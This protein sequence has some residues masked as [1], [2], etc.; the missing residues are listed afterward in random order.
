VASIRDGKV[1]S[2]YSCTTDEERA[3][4]HLNRMRKQ[5][6]T[7]IGI[8]ERT[9]KPRGV[10]APPKLRQ[11]AQGS[12]FAKDKPDSKQT[13][14]LLPG[15]FG[16]LGYKTAADFENNP[17]DWDEYV[18]RYWGKMKKCGL[19]TVVGHKLPWIQN[20]ETD[21][22]EICLS[23]TQ[24]RKLFG[25]VAK[26]PRLL[27]CGAFACAW[28]KGKQR[29]VK[30]TA[31]P[32]DVIATEAAQ[33][34]KHVVKLYNAYELVN[35]ATDSRGDRDD[36]YAMTV[37]RVYPMRGEMY[38]WAESVEAHSRE[39]QVVFEDHYG[40]GSDIE[41]A[42]SSF[43]ISKTQKDDWVDGICH[44]EAESERKCRTFAR[45][46]VNTVEELGK[47]GIK[48]QDLHTG[49]V[50]VTKGGIWKIL[51]LG[52]SGTGRGADVTPLY[53]LG[54]GRMK[55]GA[56]YR[57]KGTPFTIEMI[58]TGYRIHRGGKKVAERSTKKAAL[59]WIKRNR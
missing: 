29:V 49:N 28:E 59:T 57:V 24:V 58:P 10:K 7:N 43:E 32:D 9:S 4:S 26:P 38:Q 11:P 2:W 14:M 16:R 50:G 56:L 53:G 33:G 18:E 8:V 25:T 55:R 22:R 1:Q 30:I 40:E 13:S 35:A 6:R 19:F 12:L 51:D 45:S 17:E 3:H 47:R 15:L 34:L 39:F 5:G 46:V 23:H 42:D 48:A 37:E 20:R 36:A 27:G 21:T 41:D 44:D 54:A 31:D 52:M